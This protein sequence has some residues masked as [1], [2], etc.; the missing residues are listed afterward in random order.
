M[1]LWK[2][3]FEIAIHELLYS[4]GDTV[5]CVP[6]AQ[7][8]DQFVLRR[9]VGFNIVHCGDARIDE[10][11]PTTPR[12]MKGYTALHRR[13]KERSGREAVNRFLGLL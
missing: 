2:S 13:R 11:H 1:K 7:K 10:V 12:P 5:L 3:A 8:R 6:L 9:D 4:Y